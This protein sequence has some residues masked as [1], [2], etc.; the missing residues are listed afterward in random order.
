MRRNAASVTVG[1][2]TDVLRDAS[3]GRIPDPEDV[4]LLTV[5]E[6]LALKALPH[7]RSALYEAVRRGDV[8]SIRVGSRVL[9]PTAALRTMFGLAEKPG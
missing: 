5:E 4:P 1:A 2:M 3:S 7:R 8:P 9:I 6:L